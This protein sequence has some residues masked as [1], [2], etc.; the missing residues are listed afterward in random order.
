M[1]SMNSN[2]SNGLKEKNKIITNNLDEYM[3]KMIGDKDNEKNQDSQY[4]QDDK[5][6]QEEL[7]EIDKLEI[8]FENNTIIKKKLPKNYGNKW[9]L[10]E[11]EILIKKLKTNKEKIQ[12]E[13]YS[14]TK[15]DVIGKIGKKLGRTDGGVIGELKKIIY[16]RYSKGEDLNL[17]CED[18]NLVYK[19]VKIMIKLYIEK[20]SEQKINYYEKENKLLK[21]KIE[22]IKLKRELDELC[23]TQ[24]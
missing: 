7:S 19:N 9:T 24:S 16:E 11:R 15:Y 23:K 1:N 12:N 22:N 13:A 10:E 8:E 6:K 5:T 17:I 2:I 18:L 4:S 21:L 14:I 20:E 3:N